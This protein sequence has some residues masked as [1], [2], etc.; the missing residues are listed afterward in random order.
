[1]EERCFFFV[2]FFSSIHLNIMKIEAIRKQKWL[3]KK[4]VTICLKI[5]IYFL[6][7][8]SYQ[9]KFLDQLSYSM[10]WLLGEMSVKRNI[11]LTKC[12]HW[13]RW[14]SVWLMFADFL[15]WD[16]ITAF[17]VSNTLVLERWMLSSTYDAFLTKFIFVLISL[18]KYKLR[19][20]IRHVSLRHF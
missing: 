9:G 8:V 1:M 10:T 11:L 20:V 15:G 12:T 17:A 2:V 14:S 18:L 4:S 16:S 6:D 13:F 7:E 5:F 3:K 19:I